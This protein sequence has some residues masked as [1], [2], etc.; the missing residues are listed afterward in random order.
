MTGVLIYLRMVGLS[1]L[2]K[3]LSVLRIGKEVYEIRVLFALMTD[4][5]FV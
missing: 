1:I 5:V 2:R 3:T 4:K